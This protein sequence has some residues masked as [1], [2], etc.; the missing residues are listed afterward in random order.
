VKG[1]A[2]HLVIF[3]YDKGAMMVGKMAPGKRLQFFLGSHLVPTKWL[4]PDGLKL[5]DAS[6]D[7]CTK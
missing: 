4:N 5:L 1:N 7:W 6:I 3:G 2:G